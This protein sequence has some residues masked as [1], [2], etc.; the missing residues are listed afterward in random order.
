MYPIRKAEARKL[1]QLKED[2]KILLQLGRIVPRKGIEN[3][4]RALYILKHQSD[5]V[6]RLLIVGGESDEPD[7]KTTPE[8]GRLQRIAQDLGVA[9]QLLFTGRKT[10]E[11]LKFYYSAADVFITTP[12][13]EPFGITPLEAMACG[14][15]VIGSVV[16]GIKHTVVDR[17]TGFLVPPDDPVELSGKINLLLSDPALA[18]RMKKEG[19]SRVNRWFTWAKVSQLLSDM[20]EEIIQ[21]EYLVSEKT[22]VGLRKKNQAA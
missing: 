19:I 10:R 3:V 4:I 8:I 16:G 6:F 21:P 9:D 20:Y 13:Y 15:P 1:L 11:V 18:K 7:P 2:E 17:K 12:W 5:Y 14:T 22:G